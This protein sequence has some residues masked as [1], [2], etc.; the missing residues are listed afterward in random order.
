MALANRWVTTPPARLPARLHGHPRARPVRPRACCPRRPRTAGCCSSRRT[1]AR[2]R[3]RSTSRSTP[4][5]TWIALHETTHAFEFEAHPWLRPYLA[6]RL[7]R[8]LSL[9]SGNASHARAGHAARDR[10]GAARANRAASTGWSRLMGDEQKRLF[11]ETQAVMS[12]LEGFSDYVMD[13]VGR[14]LVRGR[15][16]D[17]GAVPRAPPA[18][19][20]FRARGP[21][22]D[23]AWTSSSSSTPRASGSSAPSRRRRAGRPWPGSG[24]ARDAADRRGDRRARAAGSRGCSREPR[25]GHAGDEDDRRA[26]SRA[27]TACRSRSRSARSCRRAMRARDLERIRAAAPGSRIVNLS[28]EGL[29]DGPVDDV[30]V[31]LRGWLV[32]EAFDRLLARAP[33]LTW[34]HSATSGVERALTPAARARDVLVTNA[35]GVFSRPI[36][37]HVLLMI[38]AVSRHLPELLEL[39]RERTWQPLEGREL[40]ELTIGIVGLR[41][42]RPVR[43]EPRLR[44]RR[45]GHRD[46]PPAGGGSTARGPTTEDGFPFEPRLDRVVGPDRLPELLARIG[47]RRPRR[48]ADPR[49]RGHDRRGRGRGDEA[50]RVADQRRPRPAR[51]RHGPHPGAARQP[52]RRRGARHVPR[53]AAA[54]GLGVL[55]RCRT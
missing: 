12:L 43:G 17:L 46:A 16:E 30:E 2:P 13:E 5:R 19:Q 31:L 21:A 54:A 1:S 27:R 8:Q 44:V 38:L 24:T 52:H 6:E 55:G 51:R 18:P 25:A 29:A 53:R 26:R 45:P 28:V 4:F 35:R 32:A 49:D 48:A 50:R 14:G 41:L 37:E 47:H 20:R 39:Q 9:F 15:R 34:V 40:R 7:E 10:S 36:A 23:R 42:A 3:T 11:R 22:P 33:H